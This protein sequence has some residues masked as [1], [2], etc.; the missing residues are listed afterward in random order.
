MISNSLKHAFADHSAP[1]LSIKL[2]AEESG[3]YSLMLK[4]NGPGLPNDF[5][6]EDGKGLG[7]EIISALV[8]QINAEMSWK[9][10]EGASI[11]IRFNEKSLE[12]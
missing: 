8:A 10:N 1:K 9:T 2:K 4:D 11:T 12:H 6:P 7:F 3:D 5:D